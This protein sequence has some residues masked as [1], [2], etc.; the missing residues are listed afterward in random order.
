MLRTKGIL[1]AQAKYCCV[2]TETQSIGLNTSAPPPKRRTQKSIC[3][4]HQKPRNHH[5]S[6]KT[7]LRLPLA[8][9]LMLVDDVFPKHRH[10]QINYW[11][12]KWQAM[13]L[14]EDYSSNQVFGAKTQ[15]LVAHMTES[16]NWFHQQLKLSENI[17]TYFPYRNCGSPSM[18]WHINES[19]PRLVVT[20]S[21]FLMGKL[22]FIIWQGR[23]RWVVYHLFI[24]FSQIKD[25]HNY[26]YKLLWESLKI[27]G[28][29]MEA[30][31]KTFLKNENLGY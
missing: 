4:C 18:P 5:M 16:T 27:I 31:R 25:K 10:F 17:W 8:K 2:Y 19:V 1:N 15:S 13:M 28:V 22:I 9:F 6:L 14:S 3:L 30:F 12:V 21:P 7:A 26:S 23:K 20:A 29:K 11:E 24:S